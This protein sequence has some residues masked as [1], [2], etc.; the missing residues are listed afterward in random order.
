MPASKSDT[1]RAGDLPVWNDPDTWNF[2]AF[3]RQHHAVP[4]SVSAFQFRRRSARVRKLA[5]DDWKLSSKMTLNLGIRYGL[6]LNAFGEKFALEPWLKGNRPNDTEQFTVLASAL[7][8][9]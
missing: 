9:S 2:N 6:A 3:Q 5:Q 4:R 7:P 8:I 1:R